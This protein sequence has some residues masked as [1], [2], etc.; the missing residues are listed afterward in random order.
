MGYLLE[1]AR[2]QVD[3][4]EFS[5]LCREGGAA[6]RSGAWRQAGEVLGQALEL[7][8]GPPLADVPSQVLAEQWV[9][10]LERERSLAV[11]WR[12]EAQLQLGQA[13]GSAG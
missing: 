13:C 2:D 12:I 10:S 7:W 4:L 5:A 11:E 1:A 8:R 6:T 3:V 9:R